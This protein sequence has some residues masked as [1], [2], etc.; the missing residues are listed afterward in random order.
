MNVYVTSATPNPMHAI[1]AAAGMCYGKDEYSAKRVERC[2][3]NGHTSVAEHVSATFRIE[4]ISR[5]CLAQLT[6]HRMA[7]FSVMS[8][9]YCI[10]KGGD[11]YVMPQ[12]FTENGE[13]VMFEAAM[14]RAKRDYIHAIDKGII[15]PEDARFLLPEATKT[16]LVMTINARS[17]MNFLSLRL[18]KS[19]QW[20]IRELAEK[21]E[22]TLMEMGGE[23]SELMALLREVRNG[24]KPRNLLDEDAKNGTC[25]LAGAVEIESC[26]D[27][28][29][30]PTETCA[31]T[32]WSKEERGEH[33]TN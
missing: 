28:V 4:G 24:E 10:N 20:E 18:A 26:N 23:W 22:Q 19:A 21:I 13:E 17:L 15:K 9:R 31:S 33:A 2:L 30:G 1:S 32:R 5:S 27:C 14:D 29:L 8:Q 3:R 6:R 12:S 16:N 7:S 11:W 25:K